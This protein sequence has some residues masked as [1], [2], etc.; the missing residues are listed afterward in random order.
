[1]GGY[2][3]FK[4][5]LLNADMNG[6]DAPQNMGYPL[7]TVNDDIYFCLSEDGAPATSPASA[8]REW[9][10]RTSTRSCSRTVSWTT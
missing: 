9:A 2:D 5:T 4:T 10:C 1:M 6:W 7:N 3:I 8:R